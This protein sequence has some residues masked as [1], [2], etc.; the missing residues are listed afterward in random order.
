MSAYNAMIGDF[1]KCEQGIVRLEGLLRA[2]IANSLAAVAVSPFPVPLS[3]AGNIS[4]E[5]AYNTPY[6]I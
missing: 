5:I 1:E 4:G 6:I 3:L 2:K